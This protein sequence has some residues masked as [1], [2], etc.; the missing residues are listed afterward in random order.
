MAFEQRDMSG[1]LFKNDKKESEKHPDY[2]GSCMVDGEE[3]Y[4]SAWLKDG[5]KG[6]FMSFAFKRKEGRS[7]QA[8]TRDDSDV[9]F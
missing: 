1:I 3:Y 6:K 7:S 4:M 8:T 5:R 2:T 9:P